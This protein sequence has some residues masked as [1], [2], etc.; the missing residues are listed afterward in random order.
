MSI[1]WLTL[2]QIGPN[3]LYTYHLY[4]LP[5]LLLPK[6]SNSDIFGAAIVR[7]G[8]AG[9]GGGR[10]QDRQPLRRARV[11]GPGRTG[12]DRGGDRSGGTS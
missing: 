7:A 8:A 12:Q 1:S 11:R 10:G 5:A 9:R 4:C 3:N 6:T 2:E